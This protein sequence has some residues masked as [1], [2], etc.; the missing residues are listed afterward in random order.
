M[1][2][3]SLPWNSSQ[4]LYLDSPRPA[5]VPEPHVWLNNFNITLVNVTWQGSTA[6]R[7]NGLI[8]FALASQ[9]TLEGIVGGILVGYF[10]WHQFIWIIGEEEMPFHCEVGYRNLIQGHLG[11]LFSCWQMF[12][13]FCQVSW[14]PFFSSKWPDVQITKITI[15]TWCVI[16]LRSF[17]GFFDSEF[18][19]ELEQKLRQ[20]GK[21]EL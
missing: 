13:S 2:P 10:G 17:L 9:N 18:R 15:L 20:T 19:N 21:G 11:E 1:F 16:W 4:D 6:E 7:D 8:P 12:S 3:S 5:L 14:Q